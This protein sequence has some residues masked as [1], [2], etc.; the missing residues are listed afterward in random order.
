MTAPHQ[1]HALI[2]RAATS[3]PALASQPAANRHQPIIAQ[4]DALNGSSITERLEAAIRDYT[5][6]KSMFASVIPRSMC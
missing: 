1:W 6:L 3:D 5:R 4:D 2:S